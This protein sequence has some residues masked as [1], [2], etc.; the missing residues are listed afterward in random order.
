MIHS[1]FTRSFCKH[2]WSAVTTQNVDRRALPE[3]SA[4]GRSCCIGSRIEW[5]TSFASHCSMDTGAACPL[6]ERAGAV[7][8]AGAHKE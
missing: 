3:H 2:G 4:W 5:G 8:G 7:A 1:I 6:S